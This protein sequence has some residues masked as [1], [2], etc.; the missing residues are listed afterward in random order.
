MTLF[1]NTKHHYVGIRHAQ[2]TA[3]KAGIVI[4]DPEIGCV[5][6]GLTE[7]GIDQAIGAGEYIKTKLLSKIN[8]SNGHNGAA[9]TVDDIYIYHSDFKRTTETAYYI[10]K[11]LKL[12][13]SQTV[14]PC[15]LLRERDMGKLEK[16]PYQQ[17][18]DDQIWERDAQNIY[19][20]HKGVQSIYDISIKFKKFISNIENDKQYKNRKLI[21]IVS[22]GDNMRVY[23]S[24]AANS[25]LNKCH[26]IPYHGN[27]RVRDY[28]TMNR[29]SKQNRIA[30]L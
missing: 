12:D 6:Y 3:N 5:K 26:Q 10:A 17:I 21:I 14:F 22:H 28:T 4:S 8:N 19:H 15:K 18:L 23:Q 7:L 9:F 2:S 1:G 13:L 16:K 11:S 24:L 20:N 27:G 25:P 29:K 30:K